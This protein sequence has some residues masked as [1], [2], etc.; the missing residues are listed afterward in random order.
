[1]RETIRRIDLRTMSEEN[2]YYVVFAA[3]D[4][5]GSSGKPGHA[6]VA[7]GVEDSATSMSS[8]EAF[9]LYPDPDDG[10]KYIYSTVSG[11]ILNEA[12]NFEPSDLTARL[13]AKVNSGPFESSKEQISRW[14]TSDYNLYKKNCIHFCHSV[15]TSIELFPPDV[16]LLQFPEDYI[17]DLIANSTNNLHGQAVNIEIYKML[18]ELLAAQRAQELSVADIPSEQS[19]RKPGDPMFVPSLGFGLGALKSDE[20]RPLSQ[21]EEALLRKLHQ[22]VAVRELEDDA[23]SQHRAGGSSKI[24]DAIKLLKADLQRHRGSG[25]PARLRTLMWGVEQYVEADSREEYRY[26]SRAPHKQNSVTSFPSKSWKCNKFVADCY[27]HGAG[28]GLALVNAASGGFH[29]IKDGNGNKWPPQAN[30]LASPN[31]KLRNLSAARVIGTPSPALGEVVAFPAPSDENGHAGLHLGNGLMISAKG[32]GIEVG[33]VDYETSTHDGKGRH[34]FYNGDDSI[35]L[36][37]EEFFDPPGKLTNNTGEILLVYGPK[38]PGETHD[39]SLYFLPHDRRTPD[40]WDC[41]GFYVPN[42]R[43]ADQLVLSDVPGPAMVKYKPFQNPTI[44][45]GE[46]GRYKCPANWQVSRRGEN[47][48]PNWE[49]PDIPYSEIPQSYPEVPNHVASGLVPEVP[50]ISEDDEKLFLSLKQQ[51]QEKINSGKIKFDPG[52]ETKLKKELLRD[53]NDTKVTVKLQ[54][55]VLEL[56]KV[57]STNIRIS[58]LV[59]TQGH[60]GNGR[61]VDIGNEEIAAALLPEFAT[62]SRVAE[63]EIDEIIF[64]ATKAGQ[65]DRNKWNYDLGVKHN[66]SASTLDQHGDHIH[67]AAKA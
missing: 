16:D 55:L 1:M 36:R 67:F 63:L 18:R 37:P 22:T 42:D 11:I 60:H 45:I 54:T 62:N 8:Q 5:P 33:T 28:L 65:T 61:A 29:A 30:V 17:K 21:D 64:D 35:R 24:G 31:S 6:F 25:L 2:T 58:S 46:G 57:V 53:N 48:A 47:G 3:R 39:N 19:E 26:V 9:G 49:I 66:Y 38:L 34:R 32:T 41:D 12:T 56:S 27:A 23:S 4:S 50:E 51:L 40:N 10:L 14:Q 52:S 43:I 13:I 20:V 44:D 59:R 7:W 15:A